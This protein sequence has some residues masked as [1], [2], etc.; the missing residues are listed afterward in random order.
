MVGGMVRI[1]Q[2]IACGLPMVCRGRLGNSTLGPL[3]EPVRAEDPD[4]TGGRVSVMHADWTSGFPDR[5]EDTPRV[6]PF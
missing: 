4:A 2:E 5:K 6:E 1:R 3:D